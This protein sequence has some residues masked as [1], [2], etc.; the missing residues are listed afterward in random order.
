MGTSKKRSVLST[1]PL[2]MA[3]VEPSAGAMAAAR[4][5][6][7]ALAG[8]RKEQQDEEDEED[9]N[10]YL[11]DETS[12]MVDEDGNRV[13]HPKLLR[14]VRSDNFTYFI[15]F[16]VLVAAVLVGIQ[17]EKSLRT[18]AAIIVVETFILIIFIVEALMKL[19]AERPKML[20]YFDD[21]WNILDFA[22]VVV[23][24]LNLV[25]Q[26]LAGLDLSGAGSTIMVFRLF[27]LLRIMKFIKS[28][29]QLRIIV[30]TL[31]TSLPSLKYVSLLIL[32]I[33][34][35]YAVLGCFIFG[36]NDVKYFGNLGISFIT[37]FRVMTF[38]QWA[39]ILYV[40]LYG[41][42]KEYTA[43]DVKRF[44]CTNSE[45][46]PVQSV[47]FFFTFI[48]LVSYVVLNLFIGVVIS[49]FQ[50]AS[51]EV[52]SDTSVSDIDGSFDEI[53]NQDIEKMVESLRSELQDC[54]N[55]MNETRNKLSLILNQEQEQP[56]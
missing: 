12:P 43:R 5:R 20:R 15:I 48:L 13:T 1:D 35:V 23:G 52:K 55:E 7:R 45:E 46:L 18:N 40:Q 47:V 6:E 32:L 21:G 8:Y 44:G 26:H 54:R 11:S 2:H 50:A 56:Y 9:D 25:L 36:E 34:Y 37:L 10:T 31:I 27:R 33:V 19:F 17:T 42:S 4:A 51:R 16:W 22:I 24:V 41:C 30:T 29:P 53:T 38:D 3:H 49:S 28:V 39:E 14:I